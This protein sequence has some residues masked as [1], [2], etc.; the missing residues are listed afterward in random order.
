MNDRHCHGRH[1]V[2]VVRGRPVARDVP[3]LFDDF[4]PMPVRNWEWRRAGPD[5]L[6]DFSSSHSELPRASQLAWLV[7]E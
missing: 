2:P 4:E 5:C 6:A 1:G 7:I 3:K